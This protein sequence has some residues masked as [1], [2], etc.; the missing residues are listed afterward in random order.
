MDYR[1]DIFAFGTILYEMLSGKRPFHGDSQIE[2]MHAILK[3]VFSEFPPPLSDTPPALEKITQRCLE[4]D[5]DRQ[6]PIYQR[7]GLRPRSFVFIV[8]RYYDLPHETRRAFAG[9][10]CGI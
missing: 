2:I 8:R 4:K 10:Y 9:D 6:D 1:S 3:I 5:P 7:S